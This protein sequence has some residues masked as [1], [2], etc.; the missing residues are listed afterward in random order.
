M[1]RVDSVECGY[2]KPRYIKNIKIREPKQMTYDDYR[3]YRSIIYDIYGEPVDLSD[4][5]KEYLDRALAGAK[6][7]YER[8]GN[9]SGDFWCS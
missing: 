8:S 2:D 1:E 6:S 9:L 3:A 5:C 4:R 7:D